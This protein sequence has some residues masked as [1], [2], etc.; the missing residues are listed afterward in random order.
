MSAILPSRCLCSWA[1]RCSCQTYAPPP[2]LRLRL[3]FRRVSHKRLTGAGSRNT[4]PWGIDQAAERHVPSAAAAAAA[5]PFLI[6]EGFALYLGVQKE[7][8]RE[9][10]VSLRV[11]MLITHLSDV[12]W[13]PK[14]VCVLFSEIQKDSRKARA[15]GEAN[16]FKTIFFQELSIPFDHI[17]NLRISFGSSWDMGVCQNLRARVTQVLVFASIYQGCHFGA[18]F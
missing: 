16:P 18:Y 2:S 13:T 3:G 4:H 1:I 6:R 8:N 12:G 11:I 17:P 7:N 15:T 9:T 5:A 10:G 14:C